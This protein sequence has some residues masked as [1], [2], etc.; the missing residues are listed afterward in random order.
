MNAKEILEIRKAEAGLPLPLP[1]YTTSVQAGFPSPAEDYLDKTLDLNELLISHPAATFF[2]RVAGDSMKNAGI[3]SGDTL[4]V[5]RSL[6]ARRQPDRRRHPQRGIYRQTPQNPPP[7]DL[8]A[9]GKSRLPYTGSE[10]RKR[11]PGLGRGHV[12]HPQSV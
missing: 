7:W 9:T 10:G 1:L 6:A 2:V 3:F 5:D 11:L 12:C 4:V 8:F